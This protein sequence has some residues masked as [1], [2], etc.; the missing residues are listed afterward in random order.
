MTD[1]DWYDEN[2]EDTNQD[3]QNLVQNLRA[4]LKAKAKT[5]KELADKLTALEVRVR[6]QDVG[7]VLKSAGVNE[8]VARLI[9]SDVEPTAEAVNKWLEEYKDVFG[10][11]VTE[12]PTEPDP[13]VVSQMTAMSNVANSGQ[14]PG[15]PSNVTAQDFQ[16]AASLED[17]MALINKGGG[18][19]P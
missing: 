9:P 5:E 16:S 15:G 1:N 12:T 2:D 14:V 8:K 3:G 11:T 4:Q 6:V 10:I 18:Y 7:A 19:A 17:V 13:D